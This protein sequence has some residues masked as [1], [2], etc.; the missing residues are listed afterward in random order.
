MTTTTS[1]AI[2]SNANDDDDFF[3]ITENNESMWNDDNTLRPWL[4]QSDPTAMIATT[5]KTTRGTKELRH[6]A[7]QNEKWD[8]MF[9]QFLIYRGKRR[10]ATTTTSVP[11]DYKSNQQPEKLRTWITWQRTNHKNNK[12]SKGRINRLESIGFVFTAHDAKW[13]ELFDRLLAYKKG[14]NG[15]TSVPF[16]YKEDQKLAKWV[17]TQRRFYKK[18][19][20]S[21]GRINRLESINFL[22]YPLD[23]RWIAMYQRLVDYRMVH[24]STDVPQDY[25]K[26]LALAKWV[27]NQRTSHNDKTIPYSRKVLLESIGFDWEVTTEGTNHNKRWNVFDHNNDL[28]SINRLCAKEFA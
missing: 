20:L 19:V 27:Q 21:V 2:V 14:H 15:S 28:L 6:T 18:K 9:Q 1:W 13:T 25:W 23:V 22:W 17:Q 3:S 24:N 12:L 8:T 11:R 5:T 26:D 10:S 4:A 16:P 7:I